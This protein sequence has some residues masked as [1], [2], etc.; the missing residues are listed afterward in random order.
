MRTGVVIPYFQREP[1]ILAGALQSV[2]QQEGVP[3]LHV[4]IVDDASPVPAEL[5][6]ATLPP[7][8]RGRVTI[9]HQQNGGPGA[10]RNTALN[11]LGSDVEFVA[12][13]DSDDRWAT[14][15]LATALTALKHDYDVYFS[16]LLDFDSPVDYFRRR[17]GLWRAEHSPLDSEGK[18]FGFTGR[19]TGQ[20]IQAN[21]IQLS[22]VVF[23]RAV[24]PQL[25]FRTEFRRAGEDILFWL[26]LARRTNRFCY[27]TAVEVH[28]GRGVNI[29]RSA[30]NGS[31]GAFERLRDETTFRRTVIREFAIEQDDR[32][33]A[34]RA[35]RDVRKQFAAELL[36]RLRRTRSV[37]LGE[38]RKQWRL[39]PWSVLSLPTNC[40]RCAA[41]WLTA[42]ASAS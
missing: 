4:V 33:N 29:Y 27:S 21:F 31:E 42:S 14:D 35:L 3:D 19:M 6:V 40:T 2:F 23:R 28:Y 10:A 22:T 26:D 32:R 12:F 7:Q 17:G 13:L 39:D 8:H 34:L 25:R 20:I 1:G 5:D 36:Y 30:T 16:N 15:H 18:V 9:K 38:I 37:S 41:D 11:A 24:A